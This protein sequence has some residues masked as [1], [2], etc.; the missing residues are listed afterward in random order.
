MFY[1]LFLWHIAFFWCCLFLYFL[2]LFHEQLVVWSDW[3]KCITDLMK[4][5][6]IVFECPSSKIARPFFLKRTGCLKCRTFEHVIPVTT[7][8][9]NSVL[10]PELL[11]WANLMCLPQS[12]LWLPPCRIFLS[13]ALEGFWLAKIKHELLRLPSAADGPK[14][15]S[16]VCVC[17]CVRESVCHLSPCTVI[18]TRGGSNTKWHVNWKNEW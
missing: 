1:F 5:C 14:H 17:V 4:W 9:V 8:E 16:R 15:R 7:G 18:L 11:L 6:W 13:L 12:L 3:S 10:Y 2:F